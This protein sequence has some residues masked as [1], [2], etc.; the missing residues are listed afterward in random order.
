[1]CIGKKNKNTDRKRLLSSTSFLPFIALSVPS[2][3]SVSTSLCFLLLLLFSVSK[4]KTNSNTIENFW[5]KH[6]TTTRKTDEMLESTSFFQCQCWATDKKEH[7][8]FTTQKKLGTAFHN[9]KQKNNEKKLCPNHNRWPHFAWEKNRGFRSV[10][11]W[12]A[13]LCLSVMIWKLCLQCLCKSA[14]KIWWQK[15]CLVAVQLLEPVMFFLWTW[16]ATWIC[17]CST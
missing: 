9:S 7:T 8:E 17:V 15:V 3:M 4:K 11:Y 16:L 1:M 10:S 14:N 13:F 12:I 2:S 5:R 6:R